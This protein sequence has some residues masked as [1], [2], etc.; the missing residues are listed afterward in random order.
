MGICN[1]VVCYCLGKI[2]DVSTVALYCQFRTFHRLAIKFLIDNFAVV[3]IR[4]CIPDWESQTA[5]Q[6]SPLKQLSRY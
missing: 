4:N 2:E 6:P 3:W 1:C 5:N